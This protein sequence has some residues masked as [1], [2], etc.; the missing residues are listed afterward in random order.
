MKLKTALDWLLEKD[1][2]SMRYLALTQLLGREEADPEARS[3]REGQS[4][5]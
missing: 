4:G 5:G 3:A 1:E 2:P